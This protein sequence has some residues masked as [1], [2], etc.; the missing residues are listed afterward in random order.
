MADVDGGGVTGE[1]WW[2]EPPPGTPGRR[3]SDGGSR[4]AD[5]G[6]PCR[7]GLAAR[8]SVRGR[9]G[10]CRPCLLLSGRDTSTIYKMARPSGNVAWQLGGK[11]SSFGMGPGA[12]FWFQHHITPLDANTVS[13]FDDGG[14]PPQKEAQSRAILLDLDTS[15]MRATLR[16]AYTHP[17]G[18]AAANQ[19]SMQVLADGRTASS[20]SGT[21]HTGSSPR[22]GPATRRTGPRS[23][24]G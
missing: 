12:T 19:G 9:R 5:P 14:A 8:H 22:T 1:T 2:A 10:A 13:I 18:L 17:A 15:A 3:D 16:Q 6:G 4:R 23:R 21:S 11:Q 20:R 7:I 24:R